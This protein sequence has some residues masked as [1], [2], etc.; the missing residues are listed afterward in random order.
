MRSKAPKWGRSFSSSGGSEYSRPT[1]FGDSNGKYVKHGHDGM[2]GR[3]NVVVGS[4]ATNNNKNTFRNNQPRR[5]FKPT[6]VKQVALKVKR[7]SKRSF[8]AAAKAVQS[9]SGGG[10]KKKTR[11]TIANFFAGK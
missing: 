6:S 9:V 8:M 7:G 10:M 1:P 11:G 4:R 2:G 5:S 3:H